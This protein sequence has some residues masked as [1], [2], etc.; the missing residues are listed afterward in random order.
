MK[1]KSAVVSMIVKPVNS[2]LAEGD[3]LN[4]PKISPA[5]PTKNEKMTSMIVL[6]SLAAKDPSRMN[7]SIALFKT[8]PIY[9]SS[10]R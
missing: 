10:I 5:F 9:I 1:P 4:N 3:K 8:D 2:V 7:H 6:A